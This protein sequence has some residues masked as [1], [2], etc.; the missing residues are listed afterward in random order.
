M[1]ARP[2]WRAAGPTGLGQRA[3]DVAI[4]VEDTNIGDRSVRQIL[5]AAS[6][7]KQVP[8][9]EDGRRREIL[10]GQDW[11]LLRHDTIPKSEIQDIRTDL[12]AVH[13]EVVT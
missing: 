6:L 10:S 2:P 9:L 8:R 1:I 4:R 11:R 5:L 12:G 13:E 3:H 7:A